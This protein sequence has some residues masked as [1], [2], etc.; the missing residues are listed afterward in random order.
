MLHT[1]ESVSIYAV[2]QL[3]VLKSPDYKR[4]KNQARKSPE[5]GHCPEKVLLFD[6]NGIEKSVRLV[7]GLRCSGQAPMMQIMS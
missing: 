5:I 3:L 6:H 1:G 4:L 7:R 2:V